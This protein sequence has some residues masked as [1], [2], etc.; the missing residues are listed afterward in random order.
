R[1]AVDAH[2]IEAVAG[3]LMP[4]GDDAAH[5]RG[6]AL[7]DPARREEG[8]ADAGSGE[9]IEQPLGVAL[10]PPRPALPVLAAD[11]PPEGMDLE[12]IFD[13]DAHRI[14]ESRADCGAG[15]MC[16]RRPVPPHLA[17]DR[18]LAR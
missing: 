6:M 2:V 17:H 18:A 15:P 14:D 5:Q 9:Q 7:A 11:R 16:R 1:L 12:I 10:D 8:G 4:L 13:I 3:E